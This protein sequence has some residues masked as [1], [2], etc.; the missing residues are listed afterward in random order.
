ML[1]KAK[2]K[3]GTSTIEPYPTGNL[4]GKKATNAPAPED[5]ASNKQGNSADLPKCDVSISSVEYA[6]QC[7]CYKSGIVVCVVTFW[8]IWWQYYSRRQNKVYVA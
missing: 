3:K 6:V 1:P 8:N 7:E 4:T 2:M 5:F